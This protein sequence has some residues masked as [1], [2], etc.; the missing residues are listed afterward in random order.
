MHSHNGHRLSR[1]T[2]NSQPKQ[3]GFYVNRSYTKATPHLGLCV[4]DAYI[5]IK[6]NVFL[7]YLDFTGAFSSVDHAHLVRSLTFLGLQKD[8]IRPI[9]N[10]YSGA[11]TEF[12]TPHGHT[13]PVKVW[14]GTLR[15]DPL[16][17]LLFDILI[18]PLIKWF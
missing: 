9:S 13:S 4:E 1:E 18:E 5:Y 11:T 8:F 7:C 10:V 16:S 12:V 2:E 14:K 15:D 6:N 17:P 3:E